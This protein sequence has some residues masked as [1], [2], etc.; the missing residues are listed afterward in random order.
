MDELETVALAQEIED[1]LITEAVLRLVEAARSGFS[2]LSVASTAASLRTASQRI[3]AANSE[4]MQAAAERDTKG[5]FLLK[6][7]GEAERAQ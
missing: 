1:K 2:P 4:K 7:A 5:I 3:A 6:A